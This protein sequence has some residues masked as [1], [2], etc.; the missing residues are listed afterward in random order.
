MVVF[1]DQIPGRVAESTFEVLGAGQ[2]DDQ[3]SDVSIETQPAAG[4]L[5]QEAGW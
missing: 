4:R 2:L 5:F 1:N 3:L